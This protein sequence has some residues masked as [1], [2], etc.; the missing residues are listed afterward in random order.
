VTPAASEVE[1]VIDTSDAPFA[2]DHD[3]G[4]VVEARTTVGYL[5]LRLPAVDALGWAAQLVAAVVAS[6]EH[7]APCHRIDD[8]VPVD[9][10]RIEELAGIVGVIEDWLLHADDDTHH[11]LAEFLRGL[12]N[13]H[14]RPVGML[15]DEL[16][17]HHIALRRLT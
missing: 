7:D 10:S 4:I 14:H 2:Y 6:S 17:T 5:T 15:I 12:G 13:L 9:R 1:V 16:G 8:T 11:D 3:S